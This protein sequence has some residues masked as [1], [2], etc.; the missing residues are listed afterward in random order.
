MS[1]K[2]IVS[3]PVKKTQ[4]NKVRLFLQFSTYSKKFDKKQGKRD[5]TPQPSIYTT[6]I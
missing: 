6:H 2:P 3:Y 1:I 5:Q 4:F